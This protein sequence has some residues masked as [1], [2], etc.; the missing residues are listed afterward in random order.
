VVSTEDGNT[1]RVADLQA[2]QQGHCLDG[3]VATIDVVA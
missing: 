2:H 1:L 3:I